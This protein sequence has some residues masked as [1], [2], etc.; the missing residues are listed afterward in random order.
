MISR[1]NLERK[2]LIRK[3]FQNK[4]LLDVFV[5][6]YEATCISTLRQMQTA[7][8][9]IFPINNFA[10]Q[11]AHGEPCIGRMRLSFTPSFCAAH[12]TTI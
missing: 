3:I 11:R 6:N 8:R 1:Q 10:F 4:E 12:S 7:I 5:F 2:G 9:K